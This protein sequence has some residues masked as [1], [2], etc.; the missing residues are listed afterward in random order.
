MKY[1]LCGLIVLP[2]IFIGCGKTEVNGEV[3]I[4]NQDTGNIKLGLVTLYFMTEKQ[5]KTA[6]D[7]TSL[8]YLNYISVLNELDSIDN[9]NTSIKEYS[10]WKDLVNKY[11]KVRTSQ[12]NELR[13]YYTDSDRKTTAIRIIE[14]ENTMNEYLNRSRSYQRFITDKRATQFVIEKYLDS[15]KN[16]VI[17]DKT[18]SDGK[19]GVELNTNTTYWVYANSNRNTIDNG[20]KYLWLFEYIP[21]VKPLYLSNDNMME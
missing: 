17:Y 12:H 18:N 20:G 19:Y 2:L 4:V 10:V 6:Y 13:D 16:E 9:Y 11:K 14:C 15:V 5:Y 3:F 7:T 21:D 1:L 8:V